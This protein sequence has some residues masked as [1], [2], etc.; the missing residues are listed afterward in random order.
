MEKTGVHYVNWSPHP[1]FNH[2]YAFVLQIKP[3]MIISIHSEFPEI[4]EIILDLCENDENE[5][6]NSV[7]QCSDEIIDDWE[8]CLDDSSEDISSIEF[9][10]SCVNEDVEIPKTPFTSTSISSSDSAVTII[11]NP[12][13]L[14]NS[15]TPIAQSTPMLSSKNIL[16]KRKK[17]ILENCKKKI[18]RNFPQTKILDNRGVNYLD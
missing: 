6:L 1:T 14:E 9:N 13:Q 17:N 7:E 5:L 11:F 4:P 10:K 2:L 8:E 16:L 15:Q 18:S 3:K 12:S